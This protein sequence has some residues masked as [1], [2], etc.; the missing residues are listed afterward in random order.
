[1]TVAMLSASIAHGSTNLEYMPG[2]PRA[3]S[4]SGCQGLDGDNDEVAC[5]SLP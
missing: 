5:E 1:V 2:V 4:Q 3:L